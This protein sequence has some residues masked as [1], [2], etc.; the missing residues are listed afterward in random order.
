MGEARNLELDGGTCWK[1][2]AS[3]TGNSRI[4]LKG[5]S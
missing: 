5:L 1:E 4:I 2:T 3:D